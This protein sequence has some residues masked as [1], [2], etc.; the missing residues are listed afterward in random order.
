MT[1]QNIRLVD[2][3]WSTQ[4]LHEK[5]KKHDLMKGDE[6]EDM[7]RGPLSLNCLCPTD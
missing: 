3:T 6:L 2:P 5:Y 4:T 1:S 7:N